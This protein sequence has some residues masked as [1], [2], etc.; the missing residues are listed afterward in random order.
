[1]TLDPWYLENLVCPVDRGT[2][3]YVNG[4]LRSENGREYPVVEGIPLM[5]PAEAEPTIGVAKASME[6]AQGI[7]VTDNRAPEFHLESLAIGE[8]EKS[9]LL[10]LAKQDRPCIDPV[11]AF[12]LR[13]TC[14][15]GYSHLLG[16][17]A[18]YPIPDLRLPSVNG[19]ELLDLGCNWGRWCIAAARK[20]YAAVG[21]DP[22]LGAVLAAR[23]VANQLGISVK[24]L[25]ADARYLPFTNS[26]FPT[27]F[28]YSVLQHL[29]KPNALHVLAEVSRVL[30][31]GGVSLIQMPNAFGI[32]SL[33]HQAKRWFREPRG[34][35]VR[36]WGVSEIQRTF[37]EHIGPSEI[38]VDC[39]FGLG[40]QKSDMALMTAGLKVVIALSDLLRRLSISLPAMKHVADSV[41]V[42]STRRRIV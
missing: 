10:E 39:Y 2:L 37:T 6:R 31:P 41:Y 28:S 18:T 13:A 26:R 27:V 29:S 35:E 3:K 15:H 30:K 7:G 4:A 40:L 19:T 34:F 22:S 25:V 23:R 33:Q 1:M 32:R 9:G 20:G 5:L 42:Y 36:Y 21:I 12:M 38:S 11:V 16:K 14:G 24:Y 8:K 17:I